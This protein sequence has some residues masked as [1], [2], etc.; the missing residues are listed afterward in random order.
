M[1]DIL[2]YVEKLE[3]LDLDGVEPTSHAL[4]L[5][6]ALQAD[7]SRPGLAAKELLALAPDPAPPY[8][9]VPKIVEGGGD[10]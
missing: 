10:A 9:R 8:V 3:E 5:T 2:G 1:T 6:G 4:D 7:A